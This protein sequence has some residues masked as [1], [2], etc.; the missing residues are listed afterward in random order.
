M[1]D[2]L[3]D[4]LEMDKKA[5]EQT[6]ELEEYRRKAIADLSEK[7]AKIIEEETAKALESAI[8]HSNKRK[9]AGDKDLEA[10]KERDGKILDK[11]NTLYALNSDKW[12]DEIV[13][14]VTR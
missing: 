13:K 7:K 4:I 14:N 11:M 1:N 5:R 3:K 2:M 12:V 8:R 9:I 10:V 6:E